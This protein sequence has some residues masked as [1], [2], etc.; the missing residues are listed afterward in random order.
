MHLNPNFNNYYQMSQ[1]LYF[2]TRGCQIYLPLFPQVTTKSSKKIYQN[3]SKKT[4]NYTIRYVQG[5]YW[6]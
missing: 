5:I 6:Q 3:S 4:K 2:W 1:Q